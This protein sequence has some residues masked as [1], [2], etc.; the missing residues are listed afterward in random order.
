MFWKGWS[1]HLALIQETHCE[2]MSLEEEMLTKGTSFKVECKI[3]ERGC[4]SLWCQ[5]KAW[6]ETT[7]KHLE[8]KEDVGGDETKAKDGIG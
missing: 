7:T 8:L 3:L 4:L 6:A 1:V 2:K 5:S